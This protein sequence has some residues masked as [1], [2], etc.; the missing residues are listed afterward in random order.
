MNSKQNIKIEHGIDKE[1]A[2]P[3]MLSNDDDGDNESNDD[4]E[5]DDMSV[6]DEDNVHNSKMVTN[7]GINDKT[8]DDGEAI[9]TNE[10]DDDID[11]NEHEYSHFKKKEKNSEINTNIFNKKSLSNLTKTENDLYFN[12]K[13]FKIDSLNKGNGNNINDKQL[14][15][16]NTNKLIKAF[17]TDLEEINNIFNYLAKVIDTQKMEIQQL[18]C[19]NDKL[20]AKINTIA[21]E[22]FSILLEKYDDKRN[23]YNAMKQ[24]NKSLNRVYTQSKEAHRKTLREMTVLKNKNKELKL[25][26]NELG[27]Q[28]SICRQNK[29][30]SSLTQCSSSALYSLEPK[31]ESTVGGGSLYNN[32]QQQ[33]SH[34]NSL[35]HTGIKRER[36]T[37]TNDHRNCKKRRI[38]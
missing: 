28:L 38:C 31:R 13:C 35:H 12:D 8:D 1:V 25:K 33:R 2:N 11:D 34:E 7:H 4:D 17:Q 24:A 9:N 15:N 5:D 22:K 20:V 29:Y 19:Q 36:G 32:Y 10:N 16:L 26:N 6:D 30:Y 14:D 23:A 21:N 18:N 3:Q 27:K 37:L